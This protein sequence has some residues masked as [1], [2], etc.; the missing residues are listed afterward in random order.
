[1][2]NFLNVQITKL[3]YIKIFVQTSKKVVFVDPFHG[4]AISVCKNAT[5]LR[6]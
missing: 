4:S 3:D 1:M 2:Q 5:T 6:Y